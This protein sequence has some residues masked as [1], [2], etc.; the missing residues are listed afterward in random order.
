M[1]SI[2]G[3]H[4]IFDSLFVVNSL[5]VVNPFDSLLVIFY[6]LFSDTV[7]V[8]L[9]HS[10]FRHTKY[11]D[12]WIRVGVKRNKTLSKLHTKRWIVLVAI[13]SNNE[14]VIWMICG[15]ICLSCDEN[16]SK[17]H[18]AQHEIQRFKS[19]KGARK[20]M[21]LS[22]TIKSFL[23]CLDI[24]CP[25]ILRISSAIRKEKRKK[26]CSYCHNSIQRNRF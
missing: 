19:W 2:H 10:F 9:S 8:F 4:Y 15:Q 24:I 16:K 13:I 26:C 11:N 18:F 6:H 23:Y 3:P 14:L 25:K 21:L 5:P 22:S 20:R 7:S 1:A 17:Q 12:D